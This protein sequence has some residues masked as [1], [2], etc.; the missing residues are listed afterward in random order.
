M[1]KDSPSLHSAILAAAFCVALLLP[2]ALPA[3][4]G[5]GA[6]AARACVAT[7]SGV[8]P[9]PPGDLTIL[10]EI[11]LGG[12]ACCLVTAGIFSGVRRRRER[13]V[14][15]RLTE[16]NR[17]L[18]LE[19]G[20]QCLA[21]KELEESRSFL[22]GI[23][24]ALA[25][26]VVVIGFDHQVVALNRAAR[27][28][29]SDMGE[30]GGYCFRVLHGLDRPCPTHAG[31]SFCGLEALG[32]SLEA[33]TVTGDHE[34]VAP[35]GKRKWCQVSATIFSA[36]DGSRRFILE[37]L[38]DITKMKEAE[39]SVRLLADFDPLTGLPNRRLFNDR[40][41]LALVQA[42]RRK[43]KVALLFLD[44]DRFKVINDTL[45]HSIGDLLLQE[46]A[47]RLRQC[48]R[49]EEDTIARQGGDEF[50]VILTEISDVAAAAKIAQ[51]VVEA[52]K[53]PFYLAGHELF[54]STSIGISIYPDDGDN[55]DRLVRNADT[56]LY[57]AKEHG[58]NGYKIYNP[59]L[60]K[61][62][63]ERLTLENSIRRALREQEF[64]LYY[65]PKVNV[66]TS[67][68]VCLEA[69]IRWNHPEFGLLLPA[70]FIQTAE[71]TGSIIPLGEWVLRTACT[72]NRKWQLAGLSP[73]R[74][75]VNLSERQ[76]TRPDVVDS[77]VEALA[78]SGLEGR[79]LDLE[80]SLELLMRS[81]EESLETLRRLTGLGVQISVANIGKG[82]SSLSCLRRLPVHT[83]KID[84]SCVGEIENDPEFASAFV[85]LAR[86]I[87]LEVIHEGVETMEQLAFFRSIACD[88]MQGNLFCRPLP[89]EEVAEILNRSSIGAI[90]K[91][92]PL[93]SAAQHA[94]VFLSAE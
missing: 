23:L 78:Q 77:V 75:A 58:K 47:R 5:E 26:P 40:L 43:E 63:M 68:I 80:I 18:V 2:V 55:A 76:F 79:W 12:A 27:S 60:N 16:K 31:R 92:A 88:E 41:T 74:V 1:P 72:Q 66:K 36:G 73:V 32:E 17:A 33:C 13:E 6:G 39:E 65:Q 46:V 59:E 3:A 38:H 53:E 25:E 44:L 15:A 9:L 93:P 24:D 10:S 62:A 21:E 94:G 52:F 45:G 54:A 86:S 91:G 49:R 29:R 87:D 57:F 82:Y 37:S 84:R 14:T 67:R 64:V 56:A 90:G 20:R 7:G 48:C 81:G 70:E 35:D 83:L 30:G 71:E 4:G 8:W 19:L 69:L 50:V 89:P 85:H 61:K 22:Q 28:F 42:H 51:E 34:W 11:C